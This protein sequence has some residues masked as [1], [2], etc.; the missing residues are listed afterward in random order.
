MTMLPEVVAVLSRYD[1]DAWS[2]LS[3]R[4]LL[5]RARKDLERVT[6]AIVAEGPEVVTVAV[7]AETVGFAAAG[8]ATATCTCPSASV[9]QHIV[10]AGLWLA[11]SAGA[12]ETTAGAD[13]LSLTP[14]ELKAFA[15]GAVYRWA[16]EY[17]EDL[18]GFQ[19]ESGQHLVLSLTTPRVRFH[20][21]GGGIAGLVPDVK[22]PNADRYQVAVVLAYQRANG[23]ELEPVRRRA[24]DVPTSAAADRRAAVRAAVGQLVEDT[25]GLGVAHLSES[26]RQRYETLTVSAQGAEYHRLA[27]MLRGA[28]G[29]ISW[30][31]AR[32]AQADEE[33]LLEQL[34]TTYGLV[35]AL[36]TVGDVP[37]L[38][39]SARG[40]FDL[41]GRQ[42][43]IGVGAVPWR[44]ASGYAGLTMVLWSVEAQEFVTWTDTRPAG[45]SFDPRGRY[46]MPGPWSGLG[47]PAEATGA[48]V[49]LTNARITA[50]GRLSG[51]D[52]THAMSEALSGAEL[53][54]ALPA[55]TS[56]SSLQT[57][58]STSLLS[59][60]GPL[61]RW[62]VLAP[63]AFG[64]AHFDEPQQRIEWPVTDADDQVLPLRMPY[65]SES[66][67][68]V[69]RIESLAP[70]APGTLVVA[71]LTRTP[72]GPTAEPLSL[73]TPTAPPGAATD[74]L[75][76]GPPRPLRPLPI[77]APPTDPAPAPPRP[78]LDHR[79]W[80]IHQAERG[81]GA[82]PNPATFTTEL[83]RRHQALRALGLT[84]YPTNPEA[85]PTAALLQSLYLTLQLTRLLT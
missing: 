76:F 32:S 27:G 81:T 82:H 44:T 78:L 57:P 72:E 65:S 5:R 1:D 16:R 48:R 8:P 13:L 46:S 80:L 69:A 31:L 37:R 61:R 49:R 43:L 36:A 4:G 59:E 63:T 40:R 7:G 66:R 38:V 19:I 53:A 79:H 67:Q 9:C 3:S 12:E 25:V 68:A 21:M 42:E 26:L 6:P 33:R 51:V 70:P 28:T 30:A 23:V 29:Q 34:A 35:T 58:Q 71:Q 10:A 83:T 52:S 41:A 55:L 62:I 22:L 14:E 39:G 20:S 18:E 64:A 17:V 45:V 50:N 2:A 77:T 15:G 60:D 75:H 54:A 73:I 11:A 85:P 47:S 84:A 56:W 74:P 24:P